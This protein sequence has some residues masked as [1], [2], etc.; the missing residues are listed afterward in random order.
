MELIGEY[1]RDKVLC[2][3]ENERKQMDLP[4]WRNAE[5]VNGLFGWVLRQ[6]KEIIECR[7]ENEARYI[8]AMWSF[9]WTDFWIP[10]DDNYLAEIVP[11]LLV[12]KEGHDEEIDARCSLYSNRKVREELRRRIYLAATL[13]NEESEEEPVE[14][15]EKEESIEE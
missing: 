15:S 2:L 9:E 8:W 7:S 1:H 11:R 5:V 12:L 10:T 3:P 4:P 6:G 13:R 14:I